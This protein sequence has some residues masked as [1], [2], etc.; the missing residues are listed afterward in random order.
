MCMDLYERRKVEEH[1]KA[2]KI[3]K[4]PHCHDIWRYDNGMVSHNSTISKDNKV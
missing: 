4:S 2:I 3:T 1:S